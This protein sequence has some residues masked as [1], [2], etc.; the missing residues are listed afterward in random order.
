MSLIRAC[1]AEGQGGQLYADTGNGV[2]A[3]MSS[4]PCV[5]VCG[6]LVLDC[7]ESPSCMRMLYFSGDVS[8]DRSNMSV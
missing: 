1:G 7:F 5:L 2:F 4:L 8:M 3:C 6:Y